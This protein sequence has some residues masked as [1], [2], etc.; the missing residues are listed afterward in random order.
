MEQDRYQKNPQLFITSMLFFIL[1]LSSLAFTAYL[2]PFLLLKLRYDV[3]EFVLYSM[4]WLQ[5]NYNLTERMATSIIFL[6]LLI[7]S[8]TVTGIAYALS[9]RLENQVNPIETETVEEAKPEG[10]TTET[11]ETISVVTKI[12]IIVVLAFIGL[13]LFQWFIYIPPVGD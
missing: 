8:L 1:S 4:H 12:I 3:P 9:N 11:K 2:L 7:I 13:M 6:G 10:L 5:L